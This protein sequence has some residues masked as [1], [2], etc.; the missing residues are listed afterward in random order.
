MPWTSKLLRCIRREGTIHLMSELMR[1][2]QSHLDRYG[3]TRATFAKRVGTT[4]QTVQNWKSRS[5]TMPRAEHLAGIARETGIPYLAVVDAALIDAGYRDSLV[6]DFDALKVRLARY[7]R[8]V[9]HGVTEVEDY[10]NRP[11]FP[12]ENELKNLRPGMTREDLNAF[13]DQLISQADA[14]Q[15]G[16]DELFDREF[17]HQ[18]LTD[19]IA[20]LEDQETTDDVETA[21]EPNAPTKAV[22]DQEAGVLQHPQGGDRPF[23][24]RGSGRRSAGQE[25]R[26]RGTKQAN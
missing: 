3:V 23:G 17:L 21:P 16:N 4:P 26:E 11:Y 19:K 24:R 9:G 22:Q 1:L 2:I 12:T 25:P 15:Y 13:I 8:E 20:E 14:A 18:Y 7:V 5:T 10:L 6:D